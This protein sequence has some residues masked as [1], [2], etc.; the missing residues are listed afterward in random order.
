MY[1][2]TKLN[3]HVVIVKSYIAV[4]IGTVL[5]PLP[6]RFSLWVIKLALS[7]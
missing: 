3:N 5:E 4:E 7:L 1:Y 6:F 2:S